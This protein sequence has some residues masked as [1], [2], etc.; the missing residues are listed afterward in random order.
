VTFSS[1]RDQGGWHGWLFEVDLDAWKAGSAAISSAFAT[2]REAECDDGTNDKLCGGGIWA[3]AGPLTESDGAHDVILL[4]TGNGRFDLKRKSFSQSLLRLRPGLHFDPMCDP[5]ACSQGNSREPSNACLSTCTDLFV[6]RLLPDEP[7][8]RPSDG[9]CDDKSFMECM[10]FKDWDFGSS[11]PVRVNVAGRGFYVAAG[12][13][14]DAYLIDAAKLGVLYD[15]RQVADPCGTKDK[16]CP[17]P[18]EG[19]TITELVSRTVDGKPIVVIATY[20]PD[21]VHAAGVVAYVVEV[22]G[23]GPKLHEA[24]RVP[25]AGSA[26]ALAWFRAPPTRPIISDVAGE[27]VVWIADNARE[28]RILAI[29][30]RDGHVLANVRTAGWPMRNAKPVIFNDV[31][32][33]PAAV[34]GRDDLTWDRGLC[35]HGTA[36]N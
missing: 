32:Y 13:A 8:L 33:L 4:Q 2:T 3:Y 34:Q 30:L 27:P 9:S 31:L 15:R 14:G 5:N 23:N 11:S 20:N 26:E 21:A 29:R 35:D 19:M 16:P 6:P 25:A 1:F 18:N 17:E 24:W 22:T 7:P 28:G 36:M 10:E 12:K